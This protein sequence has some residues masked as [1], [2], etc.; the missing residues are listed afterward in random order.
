MK[1]F[2]VNGNVILKAALTILK[3]QNNIQEWN[4]WKLM[5]IYVAMKHIKYKIHV[6]IMNSS[7]TLK[8]L[9]SLEAP[10]VS[11]WKCMLLITSAI[12]L[13]HFTYWMYTLFYKLKK[14]EIKKNHKFLI[15]EKWIKRNM[16]FA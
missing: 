3:S 6:I 5:N 10:W 8:I 4:T 7:C 16:F 1:V 15:K 2:R 9:F 12:A 14:N 11:N 13:N